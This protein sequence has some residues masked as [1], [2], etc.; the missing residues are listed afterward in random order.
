MPITPS[1]QFLSHP[2]I[3]PE[4]ARSSAPGNSALNDTNVCFPS[5]ES[6]LSASDEMGLTDED[7]GL[8]SLTSSFPTANLAPILG[9]GRNAAGSQQ[10]PDSLETALRL[11]QQL[12]CGDDH[13][14]PTSLITS[15]HDHH[16]TEA[17]QLQ[18]VIDKNKKAIEAVRSTLQTTC[19]HD[20]YLLVVVCLVV[21]KVLTTYASAV[22]VS[23]ASDDDGRRSSTSASS[24]IGKSKDSIA[25][26][27]VLDELYQVQASMDQLGAKM[28]L[29]AKRNRASSSEAF[30]IGND[31]SHTTLIGFPFSA[32]VLNQLYTEVRKRLSTLSLDLIDELKRYWT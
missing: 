10:Q 5:Y 30:P 9:V 15:G 19:S 17:P 1:Q 2:N 18:I 22:R 13:L 27:R 6:L 20:G 12:S 29:W 25:A 4:P 31:T 28:Q 8:A 3:C 24:T 26:Q 23:S 11:M 7:F 14:S 32:T 21:S 16:G